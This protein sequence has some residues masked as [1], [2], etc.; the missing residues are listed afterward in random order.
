LTEDRV[1]LDAMAA[2]QAHNLEW[3]KQVVGPGW[4]RVSRVMDLCDVLLD[5][6][7]ISRVRM[8]E[9]RVRAVSAL[10]HTAKRSGCTGILS[11]GRGQWMEAQPLFR[12]YI[13]CFGFAR[14]A[15]ASKDDAITWFKGIQDAEAYGVYQ[16]R[17]GKLLGSALKVL[18]PSIDEAFDA[19]SKGTHSSYLSMQH[20]M[21]VGG[22][23]ETRKMGVDYFDVPRAENTPAYVAVFLDTVRSGSQLIQRSSISGDRGDLE[24]HGRRTRWSTGCLRLQQEESH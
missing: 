5:A 23:K 14:I 3:F 13:E 1:L 15:W 19:F 12:R 9:E 4:A 2:T 6:F 8:H 18:Q 20:T 21:S 24:A 11:F 10:V 17:Y 16:E 7:P 22:D